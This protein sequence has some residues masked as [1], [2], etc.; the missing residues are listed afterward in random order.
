M[1]AQELQEAMAPI[2]VDWDR[3]EARVDR[4][5]RLVREKYGNGV[6]PSAKEVNNKGEKEEAA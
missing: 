2:P 6:E 4:L 5:E 1:K 3:V